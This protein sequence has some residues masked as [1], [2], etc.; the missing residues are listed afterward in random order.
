MAS[1]PDAASLPRRTAMAP[2]F[3]L[4]RL[5]TGAKLFITLSVA[6]LLL[7]LILTAGQGPAVAPQERKVRCELLSKRH[8]SCSLPEILNGHP[9]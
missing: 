8:G 9:I 3:M 5:P 2:M 6:L 1:Q 4:S 7:A